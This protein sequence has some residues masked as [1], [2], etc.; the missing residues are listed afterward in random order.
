MLLSLQ[1]EEENVDCIKCGKSIPEDAPFCCWCGKKQQQSQRKASKRGN[2]TGSVYRRGDKWVAAITKGYRIEDGQKKRIVAKKCGLKSKKEAIEYI[3]TLA[4][5]TQRE[6]DITWRTLYELWLPTH[7]A[8]K[9]TIDCYK[10]AEKYFAPL[11]FWKLKEIE[12]DDLQECLDDCPKGRRT[13]ENMK[14]L[15]GLM[16]KYGIPRGYA[17]I[18][19]AQYL[20][21]SGE[22]G[23]ER[24]SFSAE[25]IEAIRQACGK[26]AYADY[27]YCMCYLGFRPSEFLALDL[28]SYNRERRTLTGGAKT[29]A[30]KN[31]LVPISKKIQPIIT[32]LAKGRNSGKLFCDDE[33]NAFKYDKFRDSFF[34]P[35]IDAIGIQNPIINGRHKYSPHTCRHTF[36]TLMKGVIAP[37]KDKMKLIGHA[38]AEMLRDY[39]D[40]NLEDLKKIIDSI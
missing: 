27:I 7:R 39:Q 10:S 4:G 20:F 24:E 16:Y 37:D 23:E 36:A 9:S 11:E 6:K 40:V 2:G 12:I 26:V 21:V 5:K 29:A 18:N 38:S 1:K 25:Q 35:A 3:A 28:E 15:C 14:A 17:S 32:S 8:G 13:K 31:R 30:G 22:H 34:Y 19:F 33:G